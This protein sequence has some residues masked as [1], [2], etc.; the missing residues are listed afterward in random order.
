M[1]IAPNTTVK[2]LKNCPLDKS[3]ENTIYFSTLAAQTTYFSGLTG[4]TFSNQTY[5]R[6]HKGV[7]R[8]AMNAEALYNCNYMMFQNA[9]FG[10]KWFYAF[11]LSVEYINNVTSEV[12]YEIDV[13]QTW[14]FDYILKQCLVERQ[15]TTTDNPGDN[16]IPEN[17]E[18]GEYVLTDFGVTGE[19]RPYSIVVACTFDANLA[20]VTGDLYSG[21]YSGLTFHAFDNDATGV[22]ACNTFIA[23]AVNHGKATGIVSIFLMAKNMINTA[24]STLPAGRTYTQTKKISGAIDGYIPRNKKLYTY[25]FNFLYV[26]NMQGT[27]AV[28]PYE[29]FSTNDCEFTLAGDMS[30]N[31]SVVLIPEYYK[32]LTVNHDEKMVLSGYPQLSYNIDAYKAWLAQNATS[33]A[34]NSMSAAFTATINPIEGLASA[35]GIVSQVYEHAIMPNQARG[36][37]GSAT[38]CAMGY[39]EFAF[40][41]K[42]IRA[43]YLQII[44]GYFD[45]FGYACHQ[46][47]IPDRA[48]RPEWTY[49][50]TIGCKIDPAATSG[51]PGD[52][53][54][55][56]ESLYNAGIRWW[57]NPAHVGNYTYSNAPVS[58]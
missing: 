18:M 29:Y 57:T 44:D 54:E 28:Y 50:K 23:N 39:Q 52:D 8:V 36:G 5:Q 41:H 20:D 4:Y 47:K 16:T 9:S 24:G 22:A 10:N 21:V 13:L 38:N 7:I 1:Y 3:Y 46:V 32:G 55:K 58:P 2:L 37:A 43:E 25:P 33:L 48:A 14:H 45:M 27:A 12:R 17:M 40:G 19:L 49:V 30:P 26:T 42:H 31:P 35:A 34:V 6:V 15:H 56:I 53:M 11:V 51:L